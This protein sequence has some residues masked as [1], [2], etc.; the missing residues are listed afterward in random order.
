MANTSSLEKSQPARLN[1]SDLRHQSPAETKM[2]AERSLKVV[3]GTDANEPCPSKS[4]LQPKRPPCAF[5]LRASK[6]S[7]RPSGKGK[8]SELSASACL[9]TAFK[10]LHLC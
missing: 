5:K 2:M 10:S 6:N 8:R 4:R 9:V 7:C 1:R 3:R